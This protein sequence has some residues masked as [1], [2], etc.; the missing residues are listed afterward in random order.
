MFIV[1]FL[2]GLSIIVAG[3]CLCYHYLG[4]FV[5]KDSSIQ[6]I[7]GVFSGWCLA[8]LLVLA[9]YLSAHGLH[10]TSSN[11]GLR[12]AGHYPRPSESDCACG[13][14]STVQS[15]CGREQPGLGNS[16][17]LQAGLGPAQV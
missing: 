13:S 4:I 15:C 8:V 14:S 5:E 6:A 9:C 11:L 3:R 10:S 1:Q 2:M 17:L 16:N 7:L 12:L